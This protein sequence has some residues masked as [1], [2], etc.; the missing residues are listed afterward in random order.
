MTPPRIE[1]LTDLRRAAVVLQ[2][3]RLRLLHLARQP[4][5]AT[6][7]ARIVGLSRQKVN[8]HVSALATAGFL[9]PAG[10]RRRRNL[11]ERRYQA[12]AQSYV[13]HPSLLGPIGPLQIREAGDS[14]EGTSAALL[15]CLGDLAGLSSGS[16]SFSQ[17]SR[18]TFPGVEAR[19]AF[20]RA[21]G[22]AVVAAVRDH[23]AG[24]AGPASVGERWTMVLA[25]YPAGAE[26]NPHPEDASS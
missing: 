11:V 15:R 7:L 25:L 6:D 9:R 17:V 8:Y 12:S 21:I 3:L 14:A 13:L 18:I 23:A 2:P 16:T 24:A 10:T 5:S 1:Y 22:A 26:P 20:H 19:D 4:M